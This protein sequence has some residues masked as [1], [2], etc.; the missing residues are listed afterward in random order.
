MTHSPHE[1][2]LDKRQVRRA[3]SRAAPGYDEA[4]VLQREVGERLCQ[5]L[6]Y[7]RIEPGVVLDLGAGSGL[8]SELL[9]R[10]FRKAT[11]LAVDF[12][13][14]MLH[15]ARQRGS[16]RR[17]PR[18]VCAD[19]ER[20]PFP[21]GS[22][23]LVVSNLMLQ[24]CRPLASYLAEIRRLL[25]GG[26][27]FLFSTFGPDTIKELRQAWRDVDE[28]VHVHEFIDMHDVGDL[29]LA[30][31]FSEPVV[32]MEM[33]TLTYADLGGVMRDL[34]AVGATN[35]A[36]ARARGLVG[37]G[38]LRALEAA[39]ERFRQQDGRL[40]LSYEVIYGAAW[41]PNAPAPSIPPA[42]ATP[43]FAAR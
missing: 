6:D 39:Y 15:L 27:L 29:L 2:A 9:L 14:P 33:F 3:F 4:A 28:S 30:G 18:V 5:R 1:F 36:A 23:D 11:L 16:W 7:I 26:G 41:A 40:P 37:K 19:A 22:V 13:E 17:R 12:S 43:V 42:G 24:W 34:R 8:T 35:A 20:L 21:D 31:G 10:R 25:A 38:R 32:N